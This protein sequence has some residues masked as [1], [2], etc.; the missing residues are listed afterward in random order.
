M[1]SPPPWSPVR[2]SPLQGTPILAYNLTLLGFWALS[3]WAMYAVAFWLTRHRRAALIASLIFTLSPYRTDYYLE[4]QMQLAFGIPFAV[5]FVVRFL[6][7]QMLRYLA[8]LLVVLWFQAAAVW[9][10]ADILG[11]GLAVLVLRY[12]ALR[13]SGW[14][15]RRVLAA[16]LGGAL[17]ALAL[18]P[19]A[20]P[21]FRARQELGFERGLEEAAA[22]SADVL[23]YLESGLTR[24]YHF[25]PTGHIAETSLFLGFGAL[26]LAILGLGWLW[27]DR[28]VPR[29]TAER[30]LAAGAVACLGLGVFVLA[31]RG[32]LHV[33]PLRVALPPFAHSGWRYWGW[34]WSAT[35]RRERC[36]RRSTSIPSSIARPQSAWPPSSIGFRL[37]PSSSRR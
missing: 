20:W 11:F 16:A 10:Y 31:T 14:R 12:L 30:V 33:G 32:R 25:A 36:W 29:G 24:L 4:F 2:S 19:V 7:E 35:R 22:H 37:A 6:E 18:A 34:R 8:G 13:W 5:Y 28:P 17:L 27:A 9:Y 21:Y 23:T 15:A 26:A 1:R 3:G